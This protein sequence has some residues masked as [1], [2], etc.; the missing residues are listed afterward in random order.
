MSQNKLSFT[1]GIPTYN[2]SIYLK[3]CLSSI[4]ESKFI[5]EIIISDDCSVDEEIHK[6][7]SIVEKFRS[8]S[9]KNIKLFKNK[10]NKGAFF[11]K[12]FIVKQ[13]ENKVVYILDSDNLAAKNIDKV[14]YLISKK[15]DIND[16]FIQPNTMQ[17]FWKYPYLSKFISIFN[18]KYKVRFFDKDRKIDLNYIKTSLIS[19]SGGY[20]I[21]KFNIP[22]S[23]MDQVLPFK[24][25][26][27]WI[28]WILNCGNFIVSKDKFLLITKEG[29]KYDR[30]LLSIDAVVFSYLWLQSG[31]Q[32]EILKDFYHHHRKREDSVS[33]K[34]KQYSNGAIKYFIKKILTN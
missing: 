18:S 15:N 10:K 12:Y 11:N 13:S 29:L 9:T 28:M 25:I 23:V 4:V 2:S 21:D 3:D 33:F 24:Q 16:L 26:D 8:N 31:N 14:F 30:E 7:E 19:N 27:K 1:V 34:E 5:D 32:I 20:T 17:Q 6:I 22:E